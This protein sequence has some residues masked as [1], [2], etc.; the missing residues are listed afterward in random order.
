MA[1]GGGAGWTTCPATSCATGCCA[2]S[3][4]SFWGSAMSDD[5]SEVA[6]PIPESARG[7]IILDAPACTSCRISD[8]RV[9]ASNVPTDSV[10]MTQI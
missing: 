10:F 1:R 3:R 4:L 8:K 6:E 7:T 9:F 2:A 5:D